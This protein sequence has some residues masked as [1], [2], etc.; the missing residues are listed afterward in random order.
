MISISSAEL[1]ALLAAFL[2]PLARILALI[3]SAPVLSNPALPLRVRV[4]LALLITAIVAP[5]LGPPP[6]IDPGSLLGL[7]IL[8]QQIVIGVA[9]GFAIRIVFVAVEMA[10]ELAGLQMGLGFAV[11]FDPQNAGQSPVVGQFLEIVAILAFLSMDGHLQMIYLLSGSFTALP[12]AAAT[13]EAPTFFMLVEW[14]AEIFRVG[15]LLA[16]PLL[17][18]LLIANLALGVLT[19]AAPQLNLFAVGFP[20]TLALGLLMLG[21]VLPFLTPALTRLFENGLGAMA[22]LG[23]PL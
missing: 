20:L 6:A 5:T 17:A 1:N 12:V 15:V 23:G 10:G 9:L 13:L 16:L 22:R 21:L 4:A 19:R 11:F 8:A 7:L 3:M 2:W 14:G 18:S